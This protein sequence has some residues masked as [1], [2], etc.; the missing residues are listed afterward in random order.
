MWEFGSTGHYGLQVYSGAYDRVQHVRYHTK[1]V[2]DVS[3]TDLAVGTV[4][5]D[6]RGPDLVMDMHRG[7]PY[8]TL[9]QNI[10]VGA[11]RRPL[12]C[13]GDARFRPPAG[14]FTTFHNVGPRVWIHKAH[15]QLGANINWIGVHF[16]RSSLS[17]S[18]VRWRYDHNDTLR[19][20]R[21]A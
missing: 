9:W 16:G 21:R 7:A 17:F 3:V 2:H 6:I 4:F 11:G 1:F 15:D 18:P 14:A 5:D 20:A 13:F 12:R 8:A 19:G 10:D